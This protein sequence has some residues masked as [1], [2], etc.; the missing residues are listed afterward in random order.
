MKTSNYDEMYNRILSS[1]S[2]TGNDY[3]IIVKDKNK[4]RSIKQ[5]IQSYCKAIIKEGD[6]HGKIYETAKLVRVCQ[7]GE[8]III[9]LKRKLIDVVIEEIRE[10]IKM[11]DEIEKLDEYIKE[12]K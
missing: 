10:N 6:V 1:L 8:L 7:K 5:S 11:L 9:T 2:K 3:M 12:S 4:L